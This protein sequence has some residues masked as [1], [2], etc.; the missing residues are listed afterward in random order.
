MLRYDVASY[1]K[2]ASWR[3]KENVVAEDTAEGKSETC[4]GISVCY[5]LSNDATFGHNSRAVVSGNVPLEQAPDGEDTDLQIVGCMNSLNHAVD[6][7]QAAAE[8]LNVAVADR[9]VPDPTRQ[10]SMCIGTCSWCA[11]GSL[12]A[13]DWSGHAKT[14][15][16]EANVTDENVYAVR[17][18]GNRKILAQF[19]MSRLGNLV[20][21]PA[22][23]HYRMVI[24][25]NR[26]IPSERTGA[27]GNRTN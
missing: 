21:K 22:G 9:D 15:Q 20:R 17:V 3:R 1:Q 12:V 6:R 19:V 11:I 4:A 14:V 23:C 2:R 10:D 7:E 16:I 18:R 25:E 8:P 26:F 5:V 13:N 24:N 27:D